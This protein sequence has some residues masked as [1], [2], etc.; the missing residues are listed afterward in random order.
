M[1]TTLNII[2]WGQ[3][4]DIA[5]KPDEFREVNP[6]LGEHPSKGRV[7]TYFALASLAKLGITHILPS[8]YR[9]W[10]LGFN[11]AVSGYCVGNNYH[12]GARV[13]F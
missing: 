5:D 11:I 3:T 1:S 9:K 6:I 8:K 2:D 4:L 13:N 7:N 12:I 10:W